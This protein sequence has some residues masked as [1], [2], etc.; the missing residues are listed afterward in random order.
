VSQLFEVEILV[1]AVVVAD[2]LNDAWHVA[3]S[4]RREIVRDTDLDCDVVCEITSAAALPEGWDIECLPF[5]NKDDTKI[6]DYLDNLPPERDTKTIDLFEPVG[7]ERKA[8]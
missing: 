6:A 5:G 1:R 4:Q 2:N 7:A 8:P 3:H